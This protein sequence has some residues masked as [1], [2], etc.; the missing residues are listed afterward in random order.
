M[1]SMPIQFVRPWQVITPSVIRYLENVHVDAFFE[2]GSLRLSTFKR[3]RQYPC[4]QRGDLGEGRIAMEIK[5]QISHHTMVAVNGQESYILCGSTIQSIDVMKKFDGAECGINIK[6]PI[7][8][9]DA[10]ARKI[11]G[12]VGGFQGACMYTDDRTVRRNNVSDMKF[13][14]PDNE[15][16][17]EKWVEEYEKYLVQQNANESFLL[18]SMRHADQFEY[19]FVWFADGFEEDYIDIQCPEAI[20][21]CEK[22][23]FA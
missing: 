16:K 17:M 23:T 22:V 6:N 12:F 13:P 14:P 18:K 19:R 1:Q 10:V 3:F 21:F 8:F 4:E 5:N 20:Q 9:A 11:S 7:S 2:K 15:P